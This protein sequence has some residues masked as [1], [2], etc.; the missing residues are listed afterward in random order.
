MSKQQKT[1]TQQ[2]QPVQAVQAK[3][4]TFAAQAHALPKG[5][6]GKPRFTYPASSQLLKLVG[7]PKGTKADIVAAYMAEADKPTYGGLYSA[8]QSAARNAWRKG[9]VTAA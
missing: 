5:S 7:T 9:W 1:Q 3:A 2:K 8:G 4:P 6:R